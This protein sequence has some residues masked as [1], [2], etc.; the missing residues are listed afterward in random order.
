M[1]ESLV[2]IDTGA[3]C[4]IYTYISTMKIIE[5]IVMNGEQY[6]LYIKEI[7]FEKTFK[8]NKIIK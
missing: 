4:I 6:M 8:I 5:K 2:R 3:Y 1:F 7:T